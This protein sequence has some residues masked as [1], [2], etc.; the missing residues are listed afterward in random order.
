[1]KGAPWDSYVNARDSAFLSS[2]R[3]NFALEM[4]GHLPDR[5]VTYVIEPAKQFAISA[6]ATS[7]DW[8]RR[9]IFHS[10]KSIKMQNLVNK[11]FLSAHCSSSL[12]SARLK[13]FKMSLDQV[14]VVTKLLRASRNCNE[15]LL[16]DCFKDILENGITSKELN[17]TDRSGRVSHLSLFCDS[18]F[19]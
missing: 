8:L 14:E 1:M 16:K 19:L 6:L 4:A 11:T 10:R 2:I 17:S 18:D 12:L 3:I 15:L 13:A 9:K 7:I 5:H